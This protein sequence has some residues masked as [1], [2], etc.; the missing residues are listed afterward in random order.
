MKKRN[1]LPCTL[2][3]AVIAAIGATGATAGKKAKF[4]AD[5]S[6]LS[7][8]LGDQQLFHRF[9]VEYRDGAR[10]KTDRSAAAANVTR[11][12]SR[13]GLAKGRA[14]SASHLRRL[15][16]G[17]HLIKVS[18]SLDRV[19]ADALLRQLEADPNVVSVRPD[20][21]RQ[22]ARLPDVQPAYVPNDPLFVEYQWHMLAPDG[23]A[24][25]DGGPNRGGAN[26]SAAWDLADG[27]GVTI[28]VLD[29]G[30]TA[31]PD[32]DTSLA[33]AGYDFISDAFVSGRDTDDRVPGG[34]DLGDWTIGY[35]GAE[36]CQQRNSSWHGTHVAGTAGAQAT[37]NGI[38]MTGV[39][40]NANVLPIRVLGHCGGYDT[41][42]SDA[43]VWAAGGEVEG[44][45][46]NENPAHVINLS[47]GGAGAC[48][49]YE[50]DAIAQANALGAVVV[51]AAGNQNANTSNYSPG[52]CP[53]VITVASNG[54]TSR[55]AYYSNFGDGIE[56]SAPG[57]GV[58]ANDGSSGT[59]IFDGFVWQARNPSTTTPTPLA[60]INPAT[61]YGGSAGTSQAAPHVAGVVALM[62]GARL[63]A[64]MP[65]LTPAEVLDILQDTVTPFTVAP[66]ASQP[67]GPGIVNAAA[68]VAKAIEPPCEVDCAPDATPIVNGVAATGLSGTAGSE[69]LY[70]ITLPEGARGP[71][72]ITTTGGSGDVNLLVS[73]EEEPTAEDADYRSSRPGNNETV[74]VN[75]PQAGTYYIK[76]VGARAYANVRL[77]ARHN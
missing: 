40:Y 58:Y 10:E 37:D 19:E 64:G 69:T 52:N 60:G 20:R 9:V 8:S 77:T 51:V 54:V 47:L 53:G 31:H 14:T 73:F 63:D 5:T 75:A 17:Q 61:A 27:N 12:L 7:A 30:I 44:M 28:A 65:L 71:L 23:T 21:L 66:S 4:A 43:I 41:D 15:A 45:P 32:I 34:W 76:L 38:G 3:I 13:S 46:M 50:A 29:T 55:R 16:T 22:I 11:A 57:G 24:T 56:I 2:A 49:D 70:S 68:A 42:I 39:A 26:V 62:Q 59:Q 6:N 1:I 33:D 35:P 25:F 74:R 18:R 67:I 72:S 36:T 48:T